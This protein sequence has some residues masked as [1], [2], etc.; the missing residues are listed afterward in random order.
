[1]SARKNALAAIAG[2]TFAALLAGSAA[3]AQPAMSSED[4]A[5]TAAQSDQYEIMAGR[6]AVAQSQDPRVRAFAQQMIDDHT[7]T[8]EG[9]VRAVEASGLP[10]PPN[11]L[12][13]DQQRMLSALQSTKG[14][15]LDRAYVVQQVNAH[16]AA[17]A[18]EQSYAASGADANLRKA[19]QSAAPLIQHHLEMAQ[20]MK[21]SIGGS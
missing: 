20:Q 2:V 6:L 4:F 18:T 10:A 11:G 5:S 1:M 14:I 21:G 16:T 17:L 19:A 8:S 13:G 3:H 12:G 9:L 15:N 7:R